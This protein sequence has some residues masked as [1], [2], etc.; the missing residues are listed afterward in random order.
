[1]TTSIPSSSLSDREYLVRIATVVQQLEKSVGE[2]RDLQRDQEQNMPSARDWKRVTK[3][4][5]AIGIQ[6]ASLSDTFI[7]KAE[8]A[9]YKA[10]GAIIGTAVVIA[11]I[12]AVLQGVLQ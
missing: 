5:A 8:F 6:I 1:M 10:A 9:P 3:D 12:T 11:I 4:I 7:T 2:I